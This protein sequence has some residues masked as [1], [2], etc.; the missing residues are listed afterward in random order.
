MV[1]L[2]LIGLWRG[3][4]SGQE[5]EGACVD[6]AELQVVGLR[7]KKLIELEVSFTT[8]HVSPLEIPSKLHGVAIDCFG[9][10]GPEDAVFLLQNRG[11]GS[12]A[13]AERALITEY[14]ARRI[15]AEQIEKGVGACLRMRRA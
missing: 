12:S 9:Q 2:G 5:Q 3:P 10:V 8:V 14:T 4:G 6:G 7:G 1:Q 11:R 15:A 13:V